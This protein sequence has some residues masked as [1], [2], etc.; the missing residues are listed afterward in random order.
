[1][2]YEWISIWINLSKINVFVVVCFIWIGLYHN[3]L[4]YL[5]LLLICQ[6]K[7]LASNSICF[8]ESIFLLIL[9]IRAFIYYI[10][11][12]ELKNM[13]QMP[14]YQTTIYLL[15]EWIIMFNQIKVMEPNKLKY[16]QLNSRFSSLK[17]YQNQ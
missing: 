15:T 12:D 9:L 7:N 8:F 6:M 11:M 3:I 4:S 13:P 14:L 10:R 5:I 17:M 2:V 1:M 16:L